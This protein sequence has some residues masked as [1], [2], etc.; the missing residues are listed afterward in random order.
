[1]LQE[2]GNQKYQSYLRKHINGL[3]GHI[4]F[5]CSVANYVEL[6]CHVDAPVRY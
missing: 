1:M 3:L 2:L 6:S 4:Y 5:L